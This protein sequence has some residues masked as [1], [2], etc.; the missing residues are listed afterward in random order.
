V[1]VCVCVCVCMCVYD[2]VCARADIVVCFPPPTCQLVAFHMNHGTA[3]QIRLSSHLFSYFG[4]YM[5][6]YNILFIIFVLQHCAS[7]L[8]SKFISLGRAFLSFIY[9]YP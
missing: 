8:V 6:L 9:M 7:F 2:C 4:Q 1:C 3:S 5:I